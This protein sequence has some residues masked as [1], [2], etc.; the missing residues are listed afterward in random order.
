MNATP[1]HILVGNYDLPVIPCGV[2]PRV[3]THYPAIRAQHS[4]WAYQHT[5]PL[6]PGALPRGIAQLDSLYDALMLP[7]GIAD[8]VCHHV[9]LLSAVVDCDDLTQLNPVFCE[10]IVTGDPDSPYTGPIIEIWNTIRK[11]APSE[12][13]YI[14][15]RERWQQWF[16][17]LETEKKARKKP[18]LLDVDACIQLHVGAAGINPYPVA[19]EYVMDIDVGDIALDPDIERATEVVVLHSALVNDL[20]SYR[21]ECFHGDSLNP[22]HALRRDN[23]TLQGAIDFIYRRLEALDEELSELIRSLHIRY[24]RHPL[25]ERLHQYIDNYHLL[26]AG[27]AQWH[28][29]TPR[30]YGTGYLWD[31]Q[32]ARHITVETQQLP[33]DPL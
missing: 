23:Y 18:E 12:A 6:H 14:R 2:L 17:F 27:N 7:D 30:Y 31:G 32:L 15:L 21:K 19:I 4:A 9:C 20:Y 24:T 22:I 3:N 5:P 10:Q 16:E 11:N 25:G 29:E 1:N 33:I 13:V 26:I 28:L 8:R